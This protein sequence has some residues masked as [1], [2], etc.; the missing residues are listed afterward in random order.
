MRVKVDQHEVNLTNLDKVFWPDEGYTKGDLLRYYTDL[1]RY[2]L[3]HL[4]DRPLVLVRHP[5]GIAGESFYQKETPAYAPEW[6]K[7]AAIQH[8]EKTV[9][10]TICNDLDT[11][12][13]VVNQGAIEIHPWFSRWQQHDHPDIM[14]FDLDPEPPST[15]AD[16]LPLALAIREVLKKFSLEAYPKTSGA[17]GLHL[18]VPIAPAYTHQEVA[19]AAGCVSRLVAGAFPE[20]ATVERMVKKRAGRV[21][22]DY[23]QNGWGKTVVAV[24]SPRPRPLAPV[25]M[26]LTWEEV[27]GG[28]VRPTDFTIQNALQ[29]VQARGDLFAPVAVQRQDL[30]PLMEVAR[31]GY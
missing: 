12:L 14:V 23:L 25:S 8:P 26:P 19:H 2:L 17:T 9:H 22:L 3:P 30:T 15:F 11:L 6:V 13:W 1:G 21:Y 10:Y 7:T 28:K 29:R 24:Y 18:F 5:D 20:K 4:R 31:L 16:T 27:A